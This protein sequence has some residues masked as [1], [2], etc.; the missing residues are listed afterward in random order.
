MCTLVLPVL[1]RAFVH[2]LTIWLS[3]VYVDDLIGFESI[4]HGRS[5]EGLF[6]LAACHAFVETLDG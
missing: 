1:D 4:G 5:T 3:G 2:G 6:D